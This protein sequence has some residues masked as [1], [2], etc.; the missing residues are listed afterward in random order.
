[1]KKIAVLIIDIYNV[2]FSPMLKSA[3]GVNKICRQTPT[4]S[5]YTKEQII[6]FG[7]LKG[8]VL[9]AKHIASCHP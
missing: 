6:K 5:A 7:I 4:C 3:L 8:S 2:L 1:M 9:G